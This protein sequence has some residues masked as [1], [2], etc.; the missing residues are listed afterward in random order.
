MI[1][2]LNTETNEATILPQDNDTD[3]HYRDIEMKMTNLLASAMT[4]IAID[5]FKSDVVRR[6][7]ISKV[8]HIAEA[9]LDSVLIDEFDSE[10]L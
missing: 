7:Y 9:M 10:S 3:M 6:A 4:Q 5:R 8:F 2:E 1:I